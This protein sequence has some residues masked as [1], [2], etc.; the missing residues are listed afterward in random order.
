MLNV[1]M[2]IVIMLCVIARYCVDLFHSS[3]VDL[4]DGFVK[5]SFLIFREKIENMPFFVHG[6]DKLQSVR[7]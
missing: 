6:S 1:I 2:L 4:G 3:L 7:F 5:F